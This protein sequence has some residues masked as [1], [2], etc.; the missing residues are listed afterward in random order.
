M[1]R[2][3]ASVMTLKSIASPGSSMPRLPSVYSPSVFSRKNVQSTPSADSNPRITWGKY[4]TQGE[5]V[6][7][8]VSVLCHHALVDGAQIARFYQ[9][10][11]KEM[12]CL[13][14]Q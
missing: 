13:C 12:A 6:L 2:V 7:L 5:K 8:P 1:R 9:A 10:L 14:A 4:F 11:T 3:P